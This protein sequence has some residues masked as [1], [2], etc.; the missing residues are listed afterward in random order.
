MAASAPHSVRLSSNGN[1][2]IGSLFLP[3]TGYPAPV[4]IVCH[5]AGDR[6]ENY[7]ELCQYLVGRGIA[8]LA[9]DMSGHGQSAGPRFH[10]NIRQWV[11][12]VR[13]AVEFVCKHPAI[14]SER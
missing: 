8:A 9:F 5:G 6:K 10:V 2:L 7:F 14:D 1:D 3:A 11:T 13:A 12:D 4:L